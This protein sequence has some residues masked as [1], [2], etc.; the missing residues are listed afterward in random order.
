MLPFGVR[1]PKSEIFA[2]NPRVP[3]QSAYLQHTY[4]GFEP[5]QAFDVVYGGSFEHRLLSSA[6]STMEHQRLLLGDLT[7]ETGCYDFPVIAIGSMPRDAICIGFV[8]EGV[9][10]TRYNTMSIGADEIQVY[11]AGADLLYHASAFSR[12]VI[13]KVSEDRLQQTA[14]ERSGRPLTLPLSPA[15]SVRLAPGRR[16]ALTCLADDA[17]RLAR[18]LQP[19]GGMGGELAVEIFNGLLGGYTDAL[20][21]AAPSHKPGLSSVEQRHHHLIRACERLV[22]SRE[23]PSIALAKLAKRSGYSLRALELIF[24][25][26][27]GMTPGRWFMNI[28]LNGAMRDLL[29]PEP[30]CTVSDIATKWG[31]RHMS[32]FAQQY[33]TMFGELP[34]ETLGRSRDL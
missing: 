4:S 20:V 22:L 28:R 16:A 15:V 5:S 9:S 7:L 32:R 30:A 2:E 23:E 33:R 10:H 34:S 17:M 11:H 13:L 18:S 8:A 29:V 25:R 1:Y 6:R 31:F 21:D 26:S 27:V 12:W 3:F 24:R 19:S 14:V